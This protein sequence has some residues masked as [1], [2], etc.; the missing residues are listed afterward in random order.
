MAVLSNTNLFQGM[1]L[2]IAEPDF[3]ATFMTVGLGLVYSVGQSSVAK[4]Q[5]RITN[6]YGSLHQSFVLNTELHHFY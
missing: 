1:I 2:C 3:G 5:P 6:Y 4:N